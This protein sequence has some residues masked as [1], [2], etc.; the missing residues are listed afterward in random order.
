M[1]DRKLGQ[2]Y[3]QILVARLEK[4]AEKSLLTR[5]NIEEF[6]LLEEKMNSEHVAEDWLRSFHLSNDNYMKLLQKVL[7]SAIKVGEPHSKEKYQEFLEEKGSVSPAV[8][9]T[10]WEVTLSYLDA[11]IGNFSDVASFYGLGSARSS[12]HSDLGA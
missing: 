3:K 8:F 11:N 4:F 12:Q 7:E 10:P 9:L 6:Q 1:S 5:K 2:N